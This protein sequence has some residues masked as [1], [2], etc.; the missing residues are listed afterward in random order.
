MHVVP[1]QAQQLWYVQQNICQNTVSIKIVVIVP[2]ASQPSRIHPIRSN[3][4]G[5]GAGEGVSSVSHV[6]PGTHTLTG[7]VSPSRFYFGTGYTPWMGPCPEF[8]GAPPP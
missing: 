5:L 3:V 7:A 6:T 4:V 8:F 2:H 1:V